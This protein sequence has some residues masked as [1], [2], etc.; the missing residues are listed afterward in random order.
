MAKGNS[1]PHVAYLTSR[2]PALSHT[3]ILRE[4]QALRELGIAVSTAS[5]RRPTPSDL[6]GA[7]EQHEARSTFNVVDAARHPLGLLAAQS[8]L[9]SHP[10]R[11]VNAL[12][13]ALRT[14]RPGLRATLWQL[15]YFVEATVLARHLH[16]IRAEHLHCHFANAPCTVAMLASELSGLPY[17]F[18]LHGPSDLEEPK[19][20][21][22]DEKVRRATFVACISH[23]ARSQCMLFSDPEYWHKL[24]IVHCGVRPERYGSQTRVTEKR[25]QT[26]LVFVG[27]LAPAK[28]LRVL[29]EAVQSLSRSGHRICITLIGDGPDRSALEAMARP[30]GDVVTF[31]GA[32]S[33]E[34]VAGRL[35]ESDVFVL[36][37]F[38]EGVPVVLMEA[39]A[40]G[41][42]T[43]ATRIAGVAE[44][45]HDGVSGLLVPPGDAESLGRAIVAL[46][47]DPNLRKNMGRSGRELVE[48]DF[49]VVSEAGRIAA[50][51]SGTAGDEVRPRPFT[52][53]LD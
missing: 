9:F 20:W 25:K 43:I 38:A 53:N 49:N 3:F 41:L 18:T 22:L 19:L 14:R 48:D 39:M 36:P 13:L 37:S 27:R 52:P 32:L 29:L 15:F 24:R 30:L 17:S 12:L 2:Y 10:K 35:A 46:S 23:F 11:Y 45:V 5:I 4:V 21:R 6:I 7:D 28:G 44:L 1:V 40:T 8:W 34:E 42:P 26:R 47:G 51:L 16:L 31:A 33:Q 50:L